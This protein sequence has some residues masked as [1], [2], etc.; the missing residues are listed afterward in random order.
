[1]DPGNEVLSDYSIQVAE[2]HVKEYIDKDELMT[3][4]QE[5]MQCRDCEDF[6]QAGIEAYNWLWRAETTAHEAVRKGIPV[7]PDV[8]KAITA[9]YRRWLRPCERA[10]AKIQ[11]QL[12]NQHC[13]SNLADFRRVCDD[14]RKRVHA[15]DTYD[16]IDDAFT[17]RIFDEEFVRAANEFLSR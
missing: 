15:F 1:M 10:E 4:H 16:A 9:L 7:S 2:R 12:L 5:A 14:V 11:E 13:P 3:L 8:V 6:L 17:G